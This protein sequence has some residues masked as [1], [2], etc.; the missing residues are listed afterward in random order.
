MWSVGRLT[1]R[2]REGKKQTGAKFSDYFDFAENLAN[3]PSHRILALFRAEADY[4]QPGLL[5]SRPYR[6]R[7]LKRR[8]GL[9][10]QRPQCPANNN[11]P[12]FARTAAF[13]SPETI[14]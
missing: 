14:F 6:S 9:P 10:L 4:R 2:V 11:S 5:R 3:V 8:T 13:P 1:S 7:S 12:K